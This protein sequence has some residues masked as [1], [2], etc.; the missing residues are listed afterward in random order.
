MCYLMHFLSFNI[1]G[2]VGPT[3]QRALKILL[4]EV[5]PDLIFLQETMCSRYQTLQNFAKIYLKWEYYATD[6]LGIFGG[7]LT[8]WKLVLVHCKEFNTVAGILVSVRFRGSTY[9]WNCLNCYAPYQNREVFWNAAVEERIV[10]L[11]NLI[12]AGDLNFTIF[13]A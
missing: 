5:H 7:L 8:G 6:S 13:Y 3:K 1:R 10:N 11:Q 4:D 12:I 2:L 9:F